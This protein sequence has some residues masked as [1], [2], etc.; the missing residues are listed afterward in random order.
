MPKMVIIGGTDCAN[1]LCISCTA[2]PQRRSAWSANTGNADIES[3]RPHSRDPPGRQ[4][5]VF[6]LFSYSSS[7][8]LLCQRYAIRI[9]MHDMF[10]TM[11]FNS[12]SLRRQTSKHIYIYRVLTPQ[13]VPSSFNL[14]TSELITSNLSA[15][16]VACG[17]DPCK[18][19][20]PHHDR[21]FSIFHDC[22]T[23]ARRCQR[24]RGSQQK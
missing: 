3:P 17:G 13:F 10:T 19:L 2:P 7:I 1:H 23:C 24:C 14:L 20:T 15:Q 4:L 5:S 9:K 22:S 12:K 16:R 6:L 8:S 18:P 11:F 21:Y